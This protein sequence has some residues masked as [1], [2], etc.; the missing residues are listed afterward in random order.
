MKLSL[1][2]AWAV[3]RTSACAVACTSA[4]A[5]AYEGT[6]SADEILRRVDE[7]YATA[8]TYRDEGTV[9]VTYFPKGSAGHTTSAPIRTTWAAPDRL[10][11]EHDDI[12]VWS[13]NSGK[14][15]ELF[16]GRTSEHASLAHALYAVQG[17]SNGTSAMAPRWLMQRGRKD[18]NRYE[19]TG[20][21]DCG[22]STCFRL[23]RQG[24]SIDVDRKT[25]AVRR[26][27]TKE[28]INPSLDT[29]REVV[30]EPAFD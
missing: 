16:L 17:V 9:R 12:A 24:V 14:A 20:T 21:V 18:P 27:V 19:L 29:E 25:F 1:R 10:R 28:T 26:H 30:L 13:E 2:T 7:R 4:C 15:K 3:A 22:R 11:F 8:K 6:P 23:A 5:S